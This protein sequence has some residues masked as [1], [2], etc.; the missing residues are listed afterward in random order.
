MPMPFQAFAAGNGLETME[1][2]LRVNTLSYMALAAM[3][4]PH[5]DASRG[6]VAVVSS[7]AGRVGLPM[8]HAG[9]LLGK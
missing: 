9:R 8:V 5:L 7:A 6:Y 4:L 3:A 1:T 2:L